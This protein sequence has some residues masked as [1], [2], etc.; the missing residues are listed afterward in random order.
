MHRPP[1]KRVKGRHTESQGGYL[2]TNREEG[3]IYTTL[4]IPQVHREVYIPLWVYLRVHR[5]A[6]TTPRVYHRVYIGLIHLGYTSGC[7]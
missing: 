1:V 4:G 2:P 3:G 5:E 7:T 6:Y